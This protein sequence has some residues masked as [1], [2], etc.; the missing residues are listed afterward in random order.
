MQLS[1]ATPLYIIA[2]Y[3]L[4]AFFGRHRKTEEGAKKRFTWSPIESVGVTLFIYFAGQ[5]IGSLIAF[6]FPALFGWDKNRIVDWISNDAVGQFIAVLLIEVITVGLLIW[7]LRRRSATLKTIGLGR[8]PKY[9]DVGFALLAL[10]GYFLAYMAATSLLKAVI[11]SLNLDQEQQIGF[12]SVMDIQLPLVFISLVVLPP[13]AEELMVRGFLYTGL[14]KGAPAAVAVIVTSGLFAMAHLQAG[15]GEPL[16][17][18]AAIDTFVLSLF[19]IALRE[20]TGSLWSSITLHALKN[21]I[22][23][24]SI[25]VFHIVK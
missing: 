20:K 10:I 15:T 5:I 2:L 17:W 18:V 25:F 11:P 22:A 9:S 12:K 19:L 23:F 7:F 14:K 8:R 3:G 6:G 24:L 21:G 4:V 13:L 1:W 16:L